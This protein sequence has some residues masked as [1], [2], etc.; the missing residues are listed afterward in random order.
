MSLFYALN[1]NLNKYNIDQ[2]V[3]V[4]RGTK[5]IIEIQNE[6]MRIPNFCREE[7]SI[8]IR[9]LKSYLISGLTIYSLDTN[10]N[11]N[12]VVNFDVNNP[13]INILGICV[14]EPSVG[15]GSKL[16]KS[17]INFAQNNN[18][19]QIKLT[20]YNKNVLQFYIKNGFKIMDTSEM[21]DSDEEEEITI[22][23]MIYNVSEKNIGGKKSKHY[24]IKFNKTK[25]NKIKNNK[26]KSKSK[27]SK[28][29]N[30]KFK[31]IKT[32]IK[33]KKNKK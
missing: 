7:S 1:S 10:N 26:S 14:P 12:G 25:N 5:T 23:K 11:I 2:D 13:Y 32:K 17:V 3:N 29:N 31:K 4:T 9:D 21:Y 24:K 19:N 16:L 18:L 27:K 30:L 22:Y 28:R 20:C 33:S 8:S 15:V 6:I